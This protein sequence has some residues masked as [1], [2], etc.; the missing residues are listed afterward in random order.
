MDNNQSNSKPIPSAREMEK[1]AEQATNYFTFEMNCDHTAEFTTI[2][3]MIFK[4]SAVYA[5]ADEKGYSFP[6]TITG[7]LAGDGH[8]N[9]VTVSSEQTQT[10]MSISNKTQGKKSDKLV[11]SLA[12]DF[13]SLN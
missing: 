10:A 4:A 12:K 1:P 3:K 6:S 9:I 8:N 13:K 11:N 2:Y 7:G 5:G